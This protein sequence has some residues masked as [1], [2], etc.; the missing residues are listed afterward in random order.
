MPQ[1]SNDEPA[2]I[3]LDRIRAERT[4]NGRS[5]PSGANARNSSMPEAKKPAKKSATKPKLPKRA[6]KLIPM[7]PLF[8]DDADFSRDAKE[9][10]Q[11]LAFDAMEAE[12]EAEALQLAK[13]ALKLDPDCVDAINIVVHGEA[14]TPKQ[15]IEGMEKAVAAGE[16]S[17]G[18]EFFAHNKG[19]FWGL[20][21][22]RP[23]M[24]ARHEL[25][26]LLR[27]EN[28]T[29]RAIGHY[30]ALLELNPNDNQGVRDSLLGAYLQ[31]RD[32]K[33]AA[34]LLQQYK[35]DASAVF[36]WGRVLERF[37]ADDKPAATRALRAA[38]QKNQFV[39]LY[40]SAQR[41]FPKDLPDMY[42]LGS[43]EEAE[44]CVIELAQ[45]WAA[46]QDAIFWL[47]DRLAGSA[48]PK[49]T[50]QKRSVH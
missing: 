7:L 50:T 20:V 31:V 8:A 19:Y 15:A 33:G 21:E 48:A 17:L 3:L 24:R 27:A 22:T 49:K 18:Q 40:F 38:R 9:Q 44:F 25:A 29:R 35:N 2:S 6:P 11:E 39:E 47:L 23:Y 46:H 14:S 34:R 30:E 43:K 26:N 45:A 4:G 37:L 12:S 5:R 36:A 28:R 42:S 16:R 41:P 13:R 10:A 1:D 32:L